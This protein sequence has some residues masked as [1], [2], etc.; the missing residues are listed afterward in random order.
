MDRAGVHEYV[1]GT[2]DA[3]MARLAAVSRLYGPATAQ[4]LDAAGLRAGMA[5]ADL[6][7]GPGD[8]TLAVARRVGPMGTVVG[9]DAAERPLELARRRA[10]DAGL[11]NVRFEQAD[12]ASWRPTEPLDAVVGRFLL[13]HLDDPVALVAL[14]ADL[15]RPGGVVA[16]LDVALGTRGALPELPLLTAFNGW[17]LETLRRAGRPVDMAL[18]L[19]GV[20]TAAGLARTTLTSAAPVEQGGGALGYSIIGGDVTSLLPVIERTGVATAAEIGPETF[21]QRLRDQAAELDAVLL[22]PLV[23]GAAARTPARRGPVPPPRRGQG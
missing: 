5:V 4:W 3:E 17:F 16:F 8:V 2:A 14:A 1:L 12:V 13:L 11:A 9:V 7:C 19:T 20:F 6:G 21:E 10:A 18:R 22:N 23:V 15:V